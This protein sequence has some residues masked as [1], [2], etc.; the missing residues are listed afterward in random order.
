MNRLLLLRS[1]ISLSNPSAPPDLS[2]YLWESDS[3]GVYPPAPP[4]AS[5]EGIAQGEIWRLHDD[6]YD[7]ISL[8][9][10]HILN[11]LDKAQNAAYYWVDAADQLPW[12][13]SGSPLLVILEWWMASRGLY[14]VHAGAVG[15]LAGGVLLLGRGGTGKSTTALACL[16]SSLMYA[17]DDHALFSAEPSPHV[18][19]LY[20]S[21]KVSYADVSR[22]PIL[23]KSVRRV[24]DA[25][26]DQALY[27]LHGYFSHKIAKGFPIRAML[28]PRVS[29]RHDTTVS[30]ASSVEALKALAPSTLFL[31]QGSLRSAAAFRAMVKVAERVPCYSLHVGT[32]LAQIPDVIQRLLE[33]P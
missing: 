5:Q 18:Y 32:D 33:T 24:N 22:F 10:H 30:P 2:I 23:N 3:T 14:V 17:S 11:V 25:E 29:G 4:W 6:R 16:D 21:G 13:E 9:A 28:L 27:F 19:S 8:S 15:T 26:G 12:S 20:G 1:N 7:M 31:L